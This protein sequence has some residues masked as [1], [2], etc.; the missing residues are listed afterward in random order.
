VHSH[1]HASASGAPQLPDDLFRNEA[2]RRVKIGLV[3][4]ELINAKGLKSDPVRVRQRVE[5]IASTYVQ[6]EQV[7]NWYYSNE[8]QLSQIEMAV[9]E[10]QVVEHV[11]ES[12]NV[13]DVDS[14]YA[15]V[16]SGRAVAGPADETSAMEST[17]LGEER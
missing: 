14:N 8:A 4:N 6:P 13:T 7:I 9:L 17:Q 1:D 12:A 15:D 2:E 10:D 3:V 11:L 16:I 5:D